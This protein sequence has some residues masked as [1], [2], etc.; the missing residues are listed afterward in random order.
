MQSEINKIINNIAKELSGNEFW[1]TGFILEFVPDF[2]KL[3]LEFIDGFGKSFANNLIRLDKIMVFILAGYL[4][5]I[6][7][8]SICQYAK[9]RDITEAT[10]S[11]WCYF[12]MALSNPYIMWAQLII[13]VKYFN[14]L[15]DH[16]IGWFKL[17]LFLIIFFQCVIAFGT[18]AEQI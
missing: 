9:S 16:T 8:I 6:S 5:F 1:I 18:A 15:F 7:F 4:L 14:L 3:I 11:K 13:N 2:R 12:L 17:A 10:N